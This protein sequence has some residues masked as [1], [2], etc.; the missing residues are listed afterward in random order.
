MWVTSMYC[1]ARSQL[2]SN[3]LK[4]GKT[5][6]HLTVPFV[7]SPVNINKCSVCK[8]SKCSLGSSCSH[9]SSVCFW[10]S[11]ESPQ[12]GESNFSPSGIQCLVCARRAFLLLGVLSVLCVDNRKHKEIKCESVS[13]T[14]STECLVRVVLWS[15]LSTYTIGKPCAFASYPLAVEPVS[16]APL[17]SK[18]AVH[19]P[20]ARE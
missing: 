10:D 15:S 17:P 13:G 2:Q 18:A 14:A 6:V 20:G 11:P 19:L 1:D 8:Q 12:Q 3:W 16:F 9:G 5:E 4:R 7:E